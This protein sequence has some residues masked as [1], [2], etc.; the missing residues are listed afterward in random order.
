MSEGITSD[1]RTLSSGDGQRTSVAILLASIAVFVVAV[2]TESGQLTALAVFLGAIFVLPCVLWH[3]PYGALAALFAAAAVPRISLKLFGLNMKVEHAIAAL[4]AVCFLIFFR[5]RLLKL[6]TADY[7]LIGFL[8]I[9]VCSSAAFSPQPGT[10]L[11]NAAIFILAVLPYWLLR[12]LVHD[13]ETLHKAVYYFLIV[14]ALEAA[15]GIFCFSSYALFDSKFGITHY[16]YLADLAAVHGSQWEPNIFG[17]YVSCFAAMFLFL[18][19]Q[20]GSAR[21][22]HLAGLVIAGIAALLSLARASW[23]GFAVGAATGVLLRADVRRFIRRFLVPALAATCVVALAAVLALRIDPVRE[24]ASSLSPETLLEDPTL[25][26][27]MIFID[28]AL[29]DIASHPWFG[30]GSNS[31]GVLWDW[32]TDEG[33]EPAWVGNIFV[34]IW[35]DSGLVGLA[36]FLG[37]VA[38]LIAQSWKL[39]KKQR[40][41]ELGILATALLVGLIVLV[42]AFQATEASTLACTWVHL[43]LL[44]AFISV[45]QQTNSI[46]KINA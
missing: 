42:L 16:S 12:E 26:H 39:F 18:Y 46:P 41:N 32:E 20:G 31:F 8:W 4:I 38:T 45:S 2:A 1:L 22:W 13:N 19:L 30:M 35:H 28:L 29:N 44:R 37:F 6:I 34:R 17:S 7:F 25:V 11:K 9:T 24:R 43:G 33:T 10:T 3:W 36:L 5:I 14:G 27:R 23:I 21:R 15:Y 40:S